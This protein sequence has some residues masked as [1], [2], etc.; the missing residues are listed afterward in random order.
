[1]KCFLTPCVLLLGGINTSQCSWNP[2]DTEGIHCYNNS[3]LLGPDLVLPSSQHSKTLGTPS[4]QTLVQ[5]IVTELEGN[6]AL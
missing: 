2:S 1:M 4:V 5:H 3:I 6:F